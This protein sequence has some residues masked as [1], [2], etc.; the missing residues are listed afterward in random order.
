M[1]SDTTSL[2]TV[3]NCHLLQPFCPILKAIAL[4]SGG[5]GLVKKK[6]IEYLRKHLGVVPSF[7]R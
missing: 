7:T 1:E 4:Q 6:Q 2:Q 5:N 3:R